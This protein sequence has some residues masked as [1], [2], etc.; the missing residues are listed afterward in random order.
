MVDDDHPA[1]ERDDVRHVVAR[2]QHGRAVAPV[3]VGDERP[4]AFLHR[5]VEPDRRLVEEQNLRSVEERADDLD[6]HPLAQRQVA[7]GLAHEV[8]DVEQLDQLVAHRGEV[9]AVD[10]IDR[11]VELER[12]E[13]RQVPLQLVAVPITSVMRRRNS[14]SRFDGTNPSTVASPDVG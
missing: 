7:H 4:D 11:A 6:L 8:A 3:V 9:R 14:R 13:R 10:A 12:V 5:H 1:A 2:Q